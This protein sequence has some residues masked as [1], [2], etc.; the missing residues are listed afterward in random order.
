MAF[1]GSPAGGIDPAL[2]A[3]AGLSTADTQHGAPGV[4]EGTA[5]DG[6]TEFVADAPATFPVRQGLSVNR[7]APGARPVYAVAG[8]PALVLNTGA[9][10]RLLAWDPP[11]FI[12]LCCKPLREIWGGSAA[13]YALAAG[14]VNNLLRSD[15][16][17]HAAGI[18]MQ[19]TFTVSAWKTSDGALHIL[20]GNLEEGLREDAD[21]GR[22]ATLVAPRSWQGCDWKSVWPGGGTGG[23]QSTPALHLG[24][25]SSLQLQAEASPACGAPD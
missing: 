13:P 4:A 16:S 6:A 23:V 5:A 15:G 1:F 11:E 12:D 9:G 7:A 2:A 21:M 14:A 17:L 10:R 25:A 18:Q 8:S 3:L 22:N 19:Q 20:A 24:M